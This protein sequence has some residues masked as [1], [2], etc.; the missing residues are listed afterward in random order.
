MDKR[1]SLGAQAVPFRIRFEPPSDNSRM[2]RHPSRIRDERLNRIEEGL[3]VTRKEPGSP[4]QASLL[5]CLPHSSKR[6]RHLLETAGGT[7]L[8]SCRFLYVAL[9]RCIEMRLLFLFGSLFG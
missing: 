1:H 3:P 7:I 5:H 8:A 4:I 6:A 2:V 9:A